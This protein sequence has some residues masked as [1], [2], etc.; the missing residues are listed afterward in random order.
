MRLYVI[1]IY[2]LYI[3]PLIESI[4][5]SLIRDSPLE[6]MDRWHKS[7]QKELQKFIQVDLLWDAF[8][9]ERS[10]IQHGPGFTCIYW[11]C[12]SKMDSLFYVPRLSEKI[13]WRKDENGQIACKA[14]PADTITL[15]VGSLL[16][17]L[18]A[19]DVFFVAG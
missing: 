6:L 17:K 11:V 16:A 10:T 2:N 4:F 5:P 19:Q 18:L 15:G 13:L 1:Y 12:N 9:L 8:R 7:E 14:C 3:Y